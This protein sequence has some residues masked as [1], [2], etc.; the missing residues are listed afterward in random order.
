ME[1]ER[2]FYY[3]VPGDAPECVEPDCMWQPSEEDGWER[4]CDEED[5]NGSSKDISD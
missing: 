2:C 3:G 5:S 4:P 1:C